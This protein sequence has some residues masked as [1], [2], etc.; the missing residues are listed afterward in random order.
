MNAISK[1][2]QYGAPR[3]GHKHLGVDLVAPC[4][5]PILAVFGGTVT[6]GNQPSGYGKFVTVGKRTYAHMSVVLVRNGQLIIPGWP[7]GL[8]GHTGDASPS[9]PKGC[10]LHYERVDHKDPTAE[11][12]GSNIL[13]KKGQSISILQAAATAVARAGG[14]FA[15]V[16]GPGPAGPAGPMG[17]N[18]SVDKLH[19]YIPPTHRFTGFFGAFKQFFQWDIPQYGL[20]V[21]GGALMLFGFA[22]ILVLIGIGGK[23]PGKIVETGKRLPVAPVRYAAKRV[24]TRRAATKETTA[25]NIKEQRR[26]E[27]KAADTGFAAERAY[28]T[29]KAREEA[30]YGGF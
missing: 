17:P 1:G 21:I 2:G 27:R 22:V 24:S 26:N 10:H 11:A 8:V 14:F 23:T 4:G 28:K 6:V 13:G 5:L 9:G 25:Y 3:N 18:G 15:P 7:I 30:K 12:V 19:P 20:I 29:T 16:I